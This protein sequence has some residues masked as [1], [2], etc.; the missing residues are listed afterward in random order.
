MAV[1]QAGVLTIPDFI[2]WDHEDYTSPEN[3][4]RLQAAVRGSLAWAQRVLVYSQHT[5]M[6]AVERLHIS[7]ERIDVVPLAADPAFSFMCSE[8]VRA[9]VRRQVGG[10]YFLS[11]GKDYPHKNLRRLIEAFAQAGLA[12]HRLVIVGESVWPGERQYLSILAHTC[13]IE[14]KVIFRDHVHDDELVALL[15]SCDAYVFP[16]LQEG[17]GLPVLEAMASCVPV[18]CSNAAS[19]PEVAGDAALLVDSRDVDAL[20]H[21]MRSVVEDQTLRVEL[22]ERGRSRA[23][24]FTWERTADLTIASYQRA[25]ETATHERTAPHPELFLR[26]FPSELPL[27]SRTLAQSDR[28]PQTRCLIWVQSN[29]LS[30]GTSYSV[31]EEL[32]RTAIVAWCR[33][34]LTHRDDIA[35]LLAAELPEH[36]DLATAVDFARA[37]RVIVVGEQESIQ[38]VGSEQSP[39]IEWWPFDE[40]V[41]R[42]WKLGWLCEGMGG[43]APSSPVALAALPSAILQRMG[44]GV[45]SLAAFSLDPRLPLAHPQRW[46]GLLPSITSPVAE[47]WLLVGDGRAGLDP[48]WVMTFR[49]LA[50]DAE[51][52]I[53]PI[54]LC[55]P[56]VVRSLVDTL[57]AYDHDEWLVCALETLETS[58]IEALRDRKPNLRLLVTTVLSGARDSDDDMAQLLAQAWHARPNAALCTILPQHASDLVLTA[59]CEELQA[60]ALDSPGD[61]LFLRLIHARRDLLASQ[62]REREFYSTSLERSFSEVGEQHAVYDRWVRQYEALSQMVAARAAGL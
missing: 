33:Q 19:L 45:E 59:V 58:D 41:S 5:R 55:V 4:E 11:V 51:V 50:S 36:V 60:A 52:T 35:F 14:G 1:A 44:L 22:I 6:Q 13:G 32:R 56:G 39:Q 62:R 7:P 42:L 10:S 54:W 49:R 53:R 38:P 18:V 46:I 30:T 61:R 17:F 9:S 8:Q 3:R 43:V 2:L 57:G 16:S 21:A 12:N 24:A 29:G 23:A 40:L 15:Q 20:A 25:Q 28:H 37:S 47:R 34:H 48:E 31:S 27:I 26:H